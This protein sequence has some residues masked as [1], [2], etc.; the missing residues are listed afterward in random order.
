MAD[1]SPYI[2]SL[3]GIKI[4]LHWSFILLL[5]F[6]LILSLYLFVIIVLLFVCVLLH[7]LAH[8]ITSKR[9]GI[10]VKKIILLPIGGASMIDMEEI[11]PKV[12]FRI[13]ISGPIASIFIGLVLGAVAVVI[14]GGS[15][16][17]LVQLLFLI[18]ILLGVFN[19]MPGF[20]LDG[21]RVF[22][23]YEQR[24][25]SFFDATKITVKLSKIVIALFILGTVVYAAIIPGYS[26]AY[27]EFIVFWDVL[28]AV[29]LYG[30]AQAE[31]QTAY[32]REMAADLKVKDAISKNYAMV[33]PGT[34]IGELYGILMK[35]HTHIILV[36][37]GKNV[38]LVEGVRLGSSL[39]TAY[40]STPVDKFCKDIP[41]IDYNKQL[42]SA[43]DKMRNDN[44]GVIAVRRFGKIVGVLVIQHVESVVALHIS[45]KNSIRNEKNNG[46]RGRQ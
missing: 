39:N 22:R 44:T 35:E 40:M 27:R 6:S 34:T 32:V 21:G 29:F 26:F 18:N 16:R 13:S 38:K 11:D 7:E 42:P 20:P 30:G 3:F 17:H 36:D 10:G 1:I 2:G 8:S 28:I 14:P 43:I 46:G 12:E 31:Y 19:L 9:N 45:R 25:H 23:S 24:K 33:K 37:Y 15:I 5:A 41:Y 4:Q